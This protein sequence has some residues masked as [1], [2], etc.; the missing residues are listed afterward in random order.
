MAINTEQFAN[1]IAATATLAAALTSSA[2]SGTLSS[3]SN[4]S[5]LSSGQQIRAAIQD[6]SSSAIEIVFITAI[7]GTT[8]TMLRGQEGT[9]AIAHVQGASIIQCLTQYHMQNLWPQPPRSVSGAGPFT[10]SVTDQIILVNQS[11]NCVVNADPTVLIPG[12]VY[13][14]NDAANQ[15]GTYSITLTPA[16]GTT[17]IG[18]VIQVNGGSIDFFTDG[19]NIRIK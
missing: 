1:Q 18:N 13:T 5:A 7:S 2:T 10:V 14:I 11:A 15:A 17:P 9:T 16:S 3:A 8:I 19:T 4:F 12:K 6:T